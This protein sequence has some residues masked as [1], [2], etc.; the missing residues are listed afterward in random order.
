MH[1]IERSTMNCPIRN[2]WH[3]ITTPEL[4]LK[5]NDKILSINARGRLVL[6]RSFDMQCKLTSDTVTCTTV[7]T[8]LEEPYVLELT[9]GNVVGEKT[10]RDLKVIERFMLSE[11][12]N[13]THLRKDIWIRNHGIPF[14]VVPLIWLINRTGRPTGPDRLKELCEADG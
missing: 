6:N 2:V 13:V 11:K 10:P 12:N 4:I 1:L 7:P 9:H 3:A 8:R 5:W 14:F